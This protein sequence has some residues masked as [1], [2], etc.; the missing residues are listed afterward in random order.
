M[1][2]AP[3]MIGHII[4]LYHKT[5]Q[6]EARRQSSYTVKSSNTKVVLA[7]DEEFGYF[8]QD[9]SM[10]AFDIRNES[11]GTLAVDR[12]TA[13]KTTEPPLC[14]TEWLQTNFFQLGKSSK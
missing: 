9:A 6:T 10:A 5:H 14:Q 4:F 11:P 13:I 12:H 7:L 1:K 3:K 8:A 2:I